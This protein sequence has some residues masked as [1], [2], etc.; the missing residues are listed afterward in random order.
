MRIYI[1]II[2]FLLAGVSVFAQTAD[3]GMFQLAETFEKGGDFEKAAA[4]YNDL[5]S[6]N[7]ANVDYFQGLVRTYK[8]LSRYTEL[9]P[10]VKKYLSIRK[11]P[12]SLS[13]Y[14][15]ILW[16]TGDNKGANEAWDAAISIEPN[17]AKTW[18]SVAESQI[19]LQLFD[20]A[21]ETLETGRRSIK[22]VNLFA[23]LLSQLYIAKSDYEKGTREVLNIFTQNFNISQTQGRLAAIMTSDKA[24]KH[25]ANQLD[26]MSRSYSNNIVF[27]Q[28]HSWFFRSIGNQNRAFE[29]YKQI[30]KMADANG[31]ELIRFAYDSQRDGEIEIALKAFEYI[32]DNFDNKSQKLNALYGYT[33]TLEEK[34]VLQSQLDRQ[35]VLNVIKRYE[36]VIEEFPNTPTAAECNF[37]MAS[38]YLDKLTDVKNAKKELE[39]II[40]DYPRQAVTADAAIMLGR[41]LIMENKFDEAKEVLSKVIN[42]FGRNLPQQLHTAQFN[43]A[44]MEFYSGNID[45]AT[46]Y[47]S[48][49]SMITI[50]DI[51]NDALAKSILI[52]VN[53]NYKDAIVIYGK[54]D[55]HKFQKN[56]DQAESLY[57]SA[58]E[59]APES[60]LAE[61]SYIEIAKIFAI[62]ANY[63]SAIIELDSLFEKYPK[64]IYG[65]LALVLQGDYYMLKNDTDNAIKKYTQLLTDYPSSIYLIEVRNKIRAVRDGKTS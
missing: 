32:I 58:I 65:D 34:I 25:V 41:I 8:G 52:S 45:T 51:A 40:K 5:W 19:T 31:R 64:T 62:R 23:D 12:E 4:I 42:T 55:L 36:R 35:E 43:L 47:F 37:R 30:D 39:R 14:G 46:E 38:L 11:N 16:L 26:E 24:K 61:R 54:A 49:L 48:R 17:S 7:P 22:N 57:R 13:L 10:A 20:K 15:E 44:L 28:L 3:R 56:Y 63:D 1:Y 29:I 21:I 59:T 53:Q 2:V 60:D 9:L 6:R 33:R 50:S 27:L 18:Q